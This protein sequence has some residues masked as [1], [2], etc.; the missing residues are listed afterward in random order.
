MKNQHQIK[1]H[2]QTERKGSQE[3]ETHDSCEHNPFLQ[4]QE[5]EIPYSTGM[6]NTARLNPWTQ[7]ISSS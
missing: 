6:E 3:G 5:S 1:L 2:S 4:L 7:E